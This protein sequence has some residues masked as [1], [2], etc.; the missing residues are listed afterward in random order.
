MIKSLKLKEKQVLDIRSQGSLESTCE[1]LMDNMNEVLDSNKLN[2]LFKGVNNVSNIIEIVEVTINKDYSH[3]TALWKSELI[4][5]FLKSVEE[6]ED[7]CCFI[8]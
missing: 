7:G 1:D 3:A 4:E 5:S 6:K 8:V 2:G